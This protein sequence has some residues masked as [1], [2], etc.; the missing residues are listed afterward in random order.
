MSHNDNVINVWTQ[1]LRRNALSGGGIEAH[2]NVKIIYLFTIFLASHL[3][4]ARS[5]P[6]CIQTRTDSSNYNA[7]LNLGRRD[8]S[9]HL[10]KVKTPEPDKSRVDPEDY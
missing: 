4:A 7:S 10:D 6:H 2:D 8:T 9:T 1:T 3:S 5:Y